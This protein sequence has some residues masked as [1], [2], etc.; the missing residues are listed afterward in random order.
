MIKN[1]DMD[2]IVSFCNNSIIDEIVT[3]KPIQILVSNDSV[4]KKSKLYLLN[5]SI[6]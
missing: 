5:Y 2:K 3:V 6:I 1:K 4:Q